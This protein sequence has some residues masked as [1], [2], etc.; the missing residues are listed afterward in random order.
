MKGFACGVLA[1]LAGLVAPALVEAQNPPKVYRIGFIGTSSTS[2]GP[3]AAHM[4]PL[5]QE[6]AQRGW[7]DGQN[8]F[9]DFRFH[10]GHLERAAAFADDFVRSHTDIILTVTDQVT[11]IVASATRTIPIVMVTSADPIGRGFARSLARPGGNLTG[12]VNFVGAEMFAKYVQLLK[13]ARPQ[14]RRLAI[15]WDHDQGM[16]HLPEMQRAAKALGMDSRLLSIRTRTDLDA[17]LTTLAAERPDAVFV[18]GAS[19]NWV[20]RARIVE[21][22][23]RHRLVSMSDLGAFAR[24]G[25]L[26]GYGPDR[27]AQLQRVAQLVDQI[28]KGANPGDLPIAQPTK[29]ELVI[30]LKTAKALGLTIP[31]SLL[32]RAD[33][34]IE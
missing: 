3:P 6:L 8:V 13:E 30:N 10:E 17:A 31:P 2:A 26:L 7:I 12:V 24:A 1:A 9:L 27:A 19:V 22:T 14:A 18:L 34:I 33:Q 21:W 23:H 20:E 29:F 28:L 15:F 4:E 11:A 5:R 25:L 16:D 32:L